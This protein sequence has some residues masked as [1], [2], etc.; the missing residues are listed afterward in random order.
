M[1][2]IKNIAA[3]VYE[4]FKSEVLT[5]IT[6]DA[7]ALVAVSL[8]YLKDEEKSLLDLAENSINGNLTWDFVVRRLNELRV[9]F[10][11]TLLSIEQIFA[12]FIQRLVT[13]LIAFFENLLKAA[14]MELKVI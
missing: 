7:P 13:R 11:N 1:N 5:A 2:D 9:D 10:V 14:V 3:D 6:T 4:G 12:S 8:Q